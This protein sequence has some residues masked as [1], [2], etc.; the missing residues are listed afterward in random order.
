MPLD[1][2]V[3][4][5]LYYYFRRKIECIIM[6]NRTKSAIFGQS[7][8]KYSL[9]DKIIFSDRIKHFSQRCKFLIYRGNFLMIFS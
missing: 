3:Y 8:I 1:C 4:R 9:H 6:L 7:L 5:I 2:K